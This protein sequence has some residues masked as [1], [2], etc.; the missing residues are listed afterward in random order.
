MWLT[1]LNRVL[2]SNHLIDFFLPVR[3]IPWRRLSFFLFSFSSLQFYSYLCGWVKDGV[4]L[5][6][7]GNV[8][9]YGV[10]WVYGSVC[11]EDV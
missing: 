9:R 5:Y 2:Q 4:S 11:D 8:M 1:A 10:D 3:S 6:S 7:E